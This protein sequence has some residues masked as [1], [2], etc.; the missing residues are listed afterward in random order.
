MKDVMV[1]TRPYKDEEGKMQT[2]VIHRCLTCGMDMVEEEFEFVCKKCG[3]R[4]SC[5]D[6]EG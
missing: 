3:N 2:E 1:I 4:A 5:C 6:G